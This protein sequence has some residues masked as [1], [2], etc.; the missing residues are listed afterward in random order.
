MSR[1]NIFIYAEYLDYSDISRCYKFFINYNIVFINREILKI[2]SKD[3]KYVSSNSVLDNSLK[4]SDLREE[5]KK[6]FKSQNDDY[7]LQVESFN[8]LILFFNPKL[9]IFGFDSFLFERLLVEKC[10]KNKILTVSF[11]HTGLGFDIN[12][13]NIYGK[14]DFYLCWNNFDKSALIRNGLVADKIILCGTE[15][16]NYFSPSLKRKK[17]LV[18][19]AT[20]NISLS[21][22]RSLSSI[23]GYIKDFCA[24][25]EF[26]RLTPK[27]EFV[28]KPHPSWDHIPFYGMI[29]QEKNLHNLRLF[30]KKDNIEKLIRSSILFLNFNSFTSLS[31]F[32][33]KVN[34]PVV[35]YLPSILSFKANELIIKDKN[36]FHLRSLEELNLF[37]IDLLNHNNEKLTNQS[38]NSLY[39]KIVRTDKKNNLK[40]IFKKIRKG[41]N[42][43]KSNFNSLNPYFTIHQA[44]IFGKIYPLCFLKSQ[45]SSDDEYLVNRLYI[46]GLSGRNN[47]LEFLWLLLLNFLMS[48]FIFLSN[49]IKNTK[50][51]KVIILKILGT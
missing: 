12:F 45:I 22:A 6:I 38:H 28:L 2:Y 13:Y 21:G 15:K 26:V 33:F 3:V 5:G 42:N 39:G 47:K 30:N 51:R 18:I 14:A 7:K 31:I 50:L 27:I 11:V 43:I 17:N 44:G 8:D 25:L 10:K 4:L 35:V 46:Y 1:D 9:C 24:L 16:Y 23:D 32:A 20:N 19:I 41:R 36:L 49:F 29:L 37:F 34:I 40:I 48:P